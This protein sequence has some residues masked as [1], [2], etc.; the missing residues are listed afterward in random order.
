[1]GYL[2]FPVQLMRRIRKHSKSELARAV[3]FTGRHCLADNT[4]LYCAVTVAECFDSRP[5]L[6]SRLFFFSVGALTKERS[7]A[8]QETLQEVCH[9]EDQEHIA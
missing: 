1:M 4:P 7:Q 2:H 3:D 9:D 6:L 5:S 8:R